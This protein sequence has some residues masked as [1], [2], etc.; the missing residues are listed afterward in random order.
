MHHDAI[1]VHDSEPTPERW[2]T[3]CLARLGR[4]APAP[5]A[6]MFLGVLLAMGDIEIY[7][8]GAKLRPPPRP[9]K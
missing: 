2:M 8:P 6:E 5:T 4:N 7:P 3:G 1:F 9:E